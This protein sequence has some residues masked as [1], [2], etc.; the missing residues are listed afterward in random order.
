MRTKEIQ[1]NQ[2]KSYAQNR[3]HPRKHPT[4]SQLRGRGQNGFTKSQKKRTDAAFEFVA[5]PS[6]FLAVVCAGRILKPTNEE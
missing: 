4:Q 1:L 5:I 6:G 3:H 2:N